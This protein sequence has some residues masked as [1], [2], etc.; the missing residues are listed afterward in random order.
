MFNESYSENRAV[1]EIMWIKKYGSAGQATYD[2]IK[3]LKKK[4][5][6]SCGIT[7]ANLR[8]H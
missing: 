1:Y 7:K 2:S 4:K 6:F 5:C 3:F 8:E